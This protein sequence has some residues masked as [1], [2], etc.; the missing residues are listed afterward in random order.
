[1]AN[2]P[3]PADLGYRMPGEWEFQEGLWLAWP[4]NHE[5]WPGKNLDDIESVYLDIIQALY[6]DETVHVLANGFSLRDKIRDLLEQRKISSSNVKL[7]IIQNNDAWI[8]DYGPNYIIQEE[9]GYKTLAFNNW[10]FDSWGKKYDWRLDDKVNDHIASAL[11]LQHFNPGAVL[12]GGAIEVNGKGLCMTTAS[13]LLDE[14]RNK[15]ATKEKME[16]LLSKYLGISQTIWLEGQCIEGDDTDGHIDNIARFVS[17]S[18]IVCVVEENESDCNYE[19]LAR[20]RKILEN[21]NNLNGGQL[22]IIPIPMP[23]PIIDDGV[24]L[25]ASYANFYIGNRKVLLPAYGIGK[26]EQVKNILSPLFPNREI[27]LINSIDLIAGLGG[28]H[29]ISQQIPSLQS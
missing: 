7:H 23:N 4:H 9:S 12:E 18:E 21:F 1:M 2:K 25:P 19:G 16:F 5:T 27:T 20:N 17:P 14:N 24:R 8:R 28:I 3:Y 29:C 13:C 15:G 10:N 22:T 11:S 6:E 26:D